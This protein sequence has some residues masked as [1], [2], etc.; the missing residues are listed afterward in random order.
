M[1]TRPRGRRTRRSRTARRSRAAR[2]PVR[3]RRRRGSGARASPQAN[4]RLSS[5]ALSAAAMPR[6][7]A[8]GLTATPP[9]NTQG[10]ARPELR[11]VYAVPT[12]SPSSSASPTVTAG[13]PKCGSI[14]GRTVSGA[15]SN[16]E[17]STRTTASRSSSD[18]ARSVIPASTAHADQRAGSST[19]YGTA[20]CR[21]A[22][23]SP[24][25]LARPRGHRVART[26]RGQQR[27]PPHPGRRHRRS[28]TAHE[29]VRS[30]SA[31]CPPIRE[32]RLSP[33]PGVDPGRATRR[34]ARPEPALP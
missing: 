3:P 22:K 32:P 30:P 12:G 18:A 1:N 34:P 11:I 10:P 33:V 19:V 25:A 2:K 20:S 7:R 4:P 5:Q 21:R 9:R 27:C 28:S 24:P 14:Q 26:N 16:A 29:G 17:L 8:S 13:D 6:R 23:A 31:G 15:S